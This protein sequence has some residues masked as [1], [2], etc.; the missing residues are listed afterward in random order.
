MP[1]CLDSLTIETLREAA[2]KKPRGRGWE[3]VVLP[4]VTLSP[5]QA[6]KCWENIRAGR[7]GQAPREAA[8][9]KRRYDR[10]RR[11]LECL[12]EELI[13]DPLREGKSTRPYV[14]HCTKNGTG[15]VA[16]HFDIEKRRKGRTNKER[17]VNEMRAL[18]DPS[19]ETPL[20]L[21]ADDERLI[22][23]TARVGRAVERRE[24]DAKLR[25]G[26][27][28]A[29]QRFHA[30][31]GLCHGDISFQNVRIAEDGRIVLIDF[32]CA[33]ESERCSPGTCDCYKGAQRGQAWVAA[34]R[35]RE[36]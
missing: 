25:L 17:Y 4:S 21:A 19:P 29:A 34:W 26:V 30:R 23:Y 1:K 31:T 27:I 10:E 32:E 8:R 24:M 22:V 12:R 15:V 9:H 28:D 35:Q 14:V 3:P 5:L 36:L 11:A 2:A 7:T 18:R 6:R 33:H 13:E 16:K 20:L